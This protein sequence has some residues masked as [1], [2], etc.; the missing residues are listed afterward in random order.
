LV[1]VYVDKALGTSVALPQAQRAAIL[2][3]EI[4]P[5]ELGDAGLGAATMAQTN[6]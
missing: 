3:V 1:Y 4:T 6:I 2:A 5:V